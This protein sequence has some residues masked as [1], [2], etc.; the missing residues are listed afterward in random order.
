MDMGIA[1]V[2]SPHRTKASAP[3]QNERALIL[4]FAYSFR[5]GDQIW[6]R[7]S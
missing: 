3:W 6:D 1:R 7:F 2:P 4:R 5:N